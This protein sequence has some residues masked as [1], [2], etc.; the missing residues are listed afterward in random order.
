[1]QN[2][3]DLTRLTDTVLHFCISKIALFSSVYVLTGSLQKHSDLGDKMPTPTPRGGPDGKGFIR[4]HSWLHLSQIR[5][6]A[7][8]V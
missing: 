6:K 3:P 8:R 4:V 2:M 5:F 1:M 7:Q